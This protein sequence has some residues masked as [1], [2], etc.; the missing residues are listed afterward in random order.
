MLFLTPGNI[1]SFPFNATFSIYN[2][3]LPSQMQRVTTHQ[4]KPSAAPQIHES[5]MVNISAVF[6][7]WSKIEDQHHNGPLTGYQ[8]D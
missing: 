1:T 7:S 5:R 2:L 4:A 3:G 8:V 6:I